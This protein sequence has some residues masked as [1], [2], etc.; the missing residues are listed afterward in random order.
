MKKVV[1]IKDLQSSGLL[2]AQYTN[3]DLCDAFL[4]Y[5]LSNNEMEKDHFVLR[6]GNKVLDLESYF[7]KGSYSLMCG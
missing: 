1:N 2:G 5:W 4:M 6:D 3:L 7:R